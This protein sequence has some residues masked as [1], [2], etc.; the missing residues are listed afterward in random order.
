M[1]TQCLRRVDSVCCGK[2]CELLGAG[3][4]R[5][6]SGPRTR[7][8][9]SDNAHFAFGVA[10][11]DGVQDLN[12]WQRVGAE[13]QMHVAQEGGC[14]PWATCA[15]FLAMHVRSTAAAPG[16]EITL[17]ACTARTSMSAAS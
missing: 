6:P 8:M 12:L 5:A 17:L 1:R 10:F 16:E 3:G 7:I 13:C 11:A 2:A 15:I 14:L 4:C 9:F